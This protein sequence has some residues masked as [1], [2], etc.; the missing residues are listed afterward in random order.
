MF[1]S[2]VTFKD[3][4]AAAVFL[5]NTGFTKLNDTLFERAGRRVELVSIPGTSNV[6]SVDAGRPLT[7]LAY[8]YVDYEPQFYLE[9]K[10][11]V[12]DTSG[13]VVKSGEEELMDIGYFTS[14]D[15]VGYDVIA[16][17]L[18]QMIFGQPIEP[19]FEL[20]DYASHQFGPDANEVES[21]SDGEFAVI[22]PSGETIW[23][24]LVWISDYNDGDR[25]DEVDYY[26][27]EPLL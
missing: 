7:R 1:D 11:E 17:S 20:A 27:E 18:H 5:T 8:P 3:K 24:E 13:A 15:D 21:H 2:S 23:A 16:R 25:S 9:A 12:L 19:G 26:R 10:Y 6:F 22:L 14:G 4:K